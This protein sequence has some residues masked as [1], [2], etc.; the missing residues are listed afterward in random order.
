MFYVKRGS[1]NPIIA[2]NNQQ[3]WRQLAAFNPAPIK[4][5]SQLHVLYRAMTDNMFHEGERLSVSSIGHT[6]ADEDSNTARFSE[7]RQLIAPEEE[8]ERYG[9]EDP[10]VTQVD[11][12][13]YIFYTAISKFPFDPDGIRVA[14]AL[15]K[16][17]ETIDERHLV[18]PFNAKAMTLFPEKVGGKWM[19]LLTANSDLPPSRLSI[20]QLNSLEQLWD[21]TFWENWYRKVDEHTLELRR[22]PG[23][24]VEV[25]APPIKTERG[26]L[27]VY[28][29]IQNYFSDERIF[30]IEAVL[31]DLDDP[32]KIVGR[33]RYPF[34]VPEES[35]EQY[36]QLSNIVFPTGALLDGD[37]LRIFY[38]ACDTVCCTAE[39]SLSALLADMA[40]DQATYAKRYKGNPIL[41]PITEH[42]WES[43]YVLNPTAIEL[44]D[45]VHILYRAVGPDNTSVIGYARS[46][47]GLAIDYRSPEPIYV[48]R[49][50]FEKKLDLPD[51]NSGCEDARIVRVDDRLYITYTGYNG[52]DAPAVA[53]SSITVSDFLA[54]RWDSWS[55]PE[56]IS[57]PGI[58][59]KD[60][61][62]FPEKI[63]DQY[64]ILHRIDH[65]VCGDFVPQ[66]DFAEHKLTRCIQMFGPRKGMWDSQKVGIA[67]PPFK[68]EQ[69][70]V[71]FYHGINEAHHYCLGAVLLDL[72]DPTIV[73]GR[74][75]EPIMEPTTKYERE[76][77]V[78]NVV[79]PCGQVVRGDTIYIYYGG[80]DKV[81]GVATLSL[82]QLIDSLA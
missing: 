53:V 28:S 9:C 16:D 51:G 80:A 2:S 43:R 41:Q 60:A 12:T 11:D 38:G 52:Q 74:T 78:G 48:P 19:V 73:L 29:H 69:G 45:T 50:D 65:H 36:G 75:A 68:T 64:M 24:H 23:D 72:D 39:L 35:Y 71:L 40:T 5:D 62:I 66:L 34:M 77:W 13:Y 15:T 49:A 26:W 31:L 25:G 30:G 14:V 8:W 6:V 3:P 47:D 76:G 22:G 57:P 46:K 7:H 61:A 27:L 59:D 54:Q 18:T 67:G 58:D 42:E 37:Q 10:R 70:W 4:K 55:L 17:F 1:D 79:F 63:N 21:K 44:E 32:R 56:L 33:T 81:V 82:Q 20:A